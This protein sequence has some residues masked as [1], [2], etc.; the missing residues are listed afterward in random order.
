MDVHLER[1]RL[2]AASIFFNHA[3]LIYFLVPHLLDQRCGLIDPGVMYSTPRCGGN[4]DHVMR[5]TFE[6]AD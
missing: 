3:H 6:E 1:I 4:V 2:I 5:A